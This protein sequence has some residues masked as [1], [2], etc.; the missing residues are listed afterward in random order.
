MVPRLDV[1][2]RLWSVALAWCSP[3]SNETTAL[4]YDAVAQAARVHASAGPTVN[5]PSFSVN[6]PVQV[7]QS[8]RTD[9]RPSWNS[10]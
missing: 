2:V 6:D 10:I 8:T 4:S 7:L 3:A 5:L 1:S 9:A